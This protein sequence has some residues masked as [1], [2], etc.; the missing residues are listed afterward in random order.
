M[1]SSTAR[2]TPCRGGLIATCGQLGQNRDGQA[3]KGSNRVIRGGSWI[4]NARNVRSAC[5]NRN[6]PGNR[7]NNLGFRLLNSAERVRK[8]RLRLNRHLSFPQNKILRRKRMDAAC[9]SSTRERTR[10]LFIK[11]NRHVDR[12][13]LQ[14]L[15]KWPST[16]L[17]QRLRARSIWI[18]CRVF[19][20]DRT[21]LLAVY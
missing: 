1:A 4:N 19:D 20:L 5:R 14:S 12:S 18:L 6:D 9:V 11:L 13:Y 21:T 17:G 8:R 2:E 15:P 16:N 3:S 7:N 10:C